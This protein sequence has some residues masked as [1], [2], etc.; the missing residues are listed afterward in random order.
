MSNTQ[1]RS[2]ISLMA[3]PRH[4]SLRRRSGGYWHQTDMKSF[5]HSKPSYKPTVSKWN[6]QYEEGKG[7]KPQNYDE[8][9]SAEILQNRLDSATERQ[10]FKCRTF[11]ASSA[12]LTRQYQIV[13]LINAESQKCHFRQYAATGKWGK[14]LSLH[15]ARITSAGCMAASCVTSTKQHDAKTW[16]DIVSGGLSTTSSTIPSNRRIWQGCARCFAL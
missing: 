9:A 14:N 11:C 10:P 16:W 8:V 7:S 3:V 13:K 5:N 2:T 12:K 1:L 4:W 6:H 15:E